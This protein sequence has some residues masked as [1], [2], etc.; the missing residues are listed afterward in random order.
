MQRPKS[1]PF[2]LF[3]CGALLVLG[4]CEGRARADDALAPPLD[5]PAER[6]RFERQIAIEVDV[7]AMLF[8]E[9]VVRVGVSAGRY[10]VIFLSPSYRRLAGLQGAGLEL[11][12]ELRPLGRGLD[13]LHI[14]VF[15][16]A[17]YFPADQGAA[18]HLRVGG[19]VGYTYAWGKLL[20]GAAVGASR[21]FVR[22]P[23]PP[24][25]RVDLVARG[26]IGFAFL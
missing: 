21:A 1:R 14:G 4:A 16:G 23:L 12:Y 2:S 26:L 13:G 10:S 18:R 24:P 15:V 5:L 9:Y 8:G 6:A 3:I 20:V 17:A 22:G 25:R 11:A 19:D 7:A